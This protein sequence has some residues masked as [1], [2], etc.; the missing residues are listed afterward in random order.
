MAKN[1]KPKKKTPTEVVD[2]LFDQ[3]IDGGQN[4]SADALDMFAK[5]LGKT[6]D[7]MKDHFRARYRNRTG[8]SDDP[9]EVPPP[10]LG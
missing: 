9:Y 2:E 5:Q 4:P 6:P 7:I 1:S 10:I 8:N 3:L